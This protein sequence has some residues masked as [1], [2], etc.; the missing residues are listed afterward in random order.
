MGKGNSGKDPVLQYRLVSLSGQE[1]EP[2]IPSKYLL[3]L[4]K[5]C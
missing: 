4:S 1:I 5:Y 2:A 3:G